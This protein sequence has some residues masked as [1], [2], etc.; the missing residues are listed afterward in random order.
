MEW[1]QHRLTLSVR[2]NTPRERRA[3]I[4]EAWYRA[5]LRAA[6]EPLVKLWQPR[7]HV[8][9]N[10]LFVQRMRTR[11]G[12]CNPEAGTIR[13]NTELAKKPADCLEFIVVHELAHL[14]EGTHNARSWPRWTDFFRDGF[15]AGNCSIACPCATMTGSTEATANQDKELV[16]GLWG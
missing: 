13:L 10:S 16:R 8:R 3:E 7:L 12:S 4:L 15:T 11:W 6:A 1:Q 9:V 14:I 5:Q 2:P